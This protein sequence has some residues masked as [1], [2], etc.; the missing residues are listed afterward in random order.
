MDIFKLTEEQEAMLH[1]MV[2]GVW[3]DADSEA[4]QVVKPLWHRGYCR[5]RESR[6]QNR[7]GALVVQYRFELD[8]RVTSLSNNNGA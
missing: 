2:T 1:E 5:I 3:I 4:F 7:D 6:V 8:E